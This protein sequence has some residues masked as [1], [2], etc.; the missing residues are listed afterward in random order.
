LPGI[1]SLV[2]MAMTSPGRC[3]QIIGITSFSGICSHANVPEEVFS[4]RS[5]LIATLYYQARCA[6]LAI[7]QSSVSRSTSELQ[8]HCTLR[9]C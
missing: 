5:L 6:I 2:E 1:Y 8:R 4:N 3:G 7:H 9:L